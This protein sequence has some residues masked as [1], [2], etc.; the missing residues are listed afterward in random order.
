MKRIGGLLLTLFF[1]AAAPVLAKPPMYV[2]YKNTASTHFNW[3]WPYHPV[4][5]FTAYQTK[6]Y[7]YTGRILYLDKNTDVSKFRFYNPQSVE[8]HEWGYYFTPGTYLRNHVPYPIFDPPR[9]Y[10]LKVK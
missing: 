8:K 7:Y 1:L 9:V 3:K 2:L 5:T 10:Y 6:P 4:S